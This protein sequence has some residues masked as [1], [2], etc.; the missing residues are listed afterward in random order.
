MVKVGILYPVFALALW[1]SLVLLQIP[2]ARFR[3]VFKREVTADD[4]K[5]G[6]SSSVPSHVSIP[7]RNYMNLLEF[8]VLFYIV[9]LLIYSAGITTLNMVTLAWAYV[10][11][12]AVHSVIHLSYNNV[13]HRLVLFAISNLVL[14]V[15]WVL[16]AMQLPN[17]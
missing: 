16:A 14:I 2:I 9:C 15:L 3:A 8:P 11:L 6:E 17:S 5:H 13:R 4:F 7:N 12:R 1:T 10:V